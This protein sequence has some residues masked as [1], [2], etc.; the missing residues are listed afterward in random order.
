MHNNSHLISK[1]KPKIRI[2][3]VFA[4]EIIKTDVANFRQMVQKLTGKPEET[5]ASSKKTTR[6]SR[7]SSDLDTTGFIN[8]NEDASNNNNN[9]MLLPD[10]H[11]WPQL[12]PEKMI[13]EEED[14]ETRDNGDSSSS[15]LA[16]FSELDG[17][18]Q[19]LSESSSYIPTKSSHP[20]MDYV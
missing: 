4:P 10:H 18:I 20:P 7:K 5:N 6:R 3:H 8:N 11:E 2:I 15:L 13:K 12:T 14:H 19:E 16:G 17:F 1:F 9:R